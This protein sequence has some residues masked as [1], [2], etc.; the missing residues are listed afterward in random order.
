LSEPLVRIQFSSIEFIIPYQFHPFYRNSIDRFF[1]IQPLR[2]ICTTTQ[3]WEQEQ[4]CNYRIYISHSFKIVNGH[5]LISNLKQFSKYLF[6]SLYAITFRL[7]GIGIGLFSPSFFDGIKVYCLRFFPIEQFG[8]VIKPC[9]PT[10][11]IE[12]F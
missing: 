2:C 11:I 1:F 3:T 4:T 7:V 10:H 8:L 5:F 6:Y 9:F 12:I